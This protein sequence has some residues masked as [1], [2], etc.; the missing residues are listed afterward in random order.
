MKHLKAK[1][2]TSVAMVL[3]AAALMATASFAWYT[4]S[5]NPE[6]ANI[7]TSVGANG[8]LEIALLSAADA[9][10]VAASA[11]GD[12]GKN[13]AWGNLVDLTAFEFKELKPCLFEAGVISIPTFGLDG[14]IVSV[15]ALNATWK[16]ATGS[17][18]FTD[19]GIFEYV[20][21]AG[22]VFAYRVDFFMRSNVAGTVSLGAAADRG[23]GD[24]SGAG[25]TI[26]ADSNI[27]IAFYQETTE[28]L[29]L[30]A[31]DTAGGTLEGDVIT[32]T[33]NTTELI[34]MYIFVDGATLTNAELLTEDL[35]VDINIQFTHSETLDPLD[36]Q[37]ADYDKTG[38]GD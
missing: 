10:D 23:A 24:E 19:G 5:T 29:T 37:G 8:N 14:R 15:D 11:E 22:N 30:D 17:G 9:T 4:I 35:D 27:T 18:N 7:S 26:T 33:E 36:I 21:T 38:A 1:L 34:S 25:S 13:A 3:V 32:L 31:E 16:A 20:D 6:I 12:A 28:L 2:L